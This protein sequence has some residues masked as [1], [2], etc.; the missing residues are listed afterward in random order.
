MLS[1][2][3]LQKISIIHP[4]SRPLVDRLSQVTK[5]VTLSKK[6]MLLGQGKICDKVYFI[7]KGIARAFHH[8]DGQDITSWLMRE[9][10]WIISVHSFYRQRP[11]YENIELLEDSIL[12]SLGYVELQSIYKDFP[13]FNFIGRVLTEYYYALSEERAFS[14]RLQSVKDRFESFMAAH[15]E[16]FNRVPLKYIASYA[17]WD[18]AFRMDL[19]VGPALI[20]P[21]KFDKEL[22]YKPDNTEVYFPISVLTYILF[23][24]DLNKE[25]HI[26]VI[27]SMPTAD[28]SDSI[29][30]QPFKGV[31]V[32]EN[33]QGDIISGFMF[34]KGEAYKISLDTQKKHPGALEVTTICITSSWYTCVTS[35]FG[36]NCYSESETECTSVTG[37]S[38]GNSG[39]AGSTAGTTGGGPS[40]DYGNIA[41]NTTYVVPGLRGNIISDIRDYLKC[42]DPTKP[43][44]VNI[45]VDQ[46]VPGTNANHDGIDVGHTFIGIT[47]QNGTAIITKYLGFYPAYDLSATPATPSSTSALGNDEGHTYDL[48]LPIQISSGQLSNLLNYI[49]NGTS[50]TYNLNSCNCTTWALNIAQ[51]CGVTLSR[52]IGCWAPLI[53]GCGVNPGDLGED[54]RTVPGAVSS[55]N[56]FA[57]AN[58][59]N[60]SMSLQ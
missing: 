34:R 15:P 21:V 4:L 56:S 54:L 19:S 35:M 50:T 45:Y 49:V 29:K 5:Q 59:G 10:D 13:E 6:T 36:S 40:T 1:E 8:K 51:I 3:I 58:T 44:T 9:G 18:K 23:Y 52:T 43:A 14:L 2:V 7:E 11:S 39:G 27:T 41:E 28:K 38:G 47:Q 17:V 57:P 42:F 55:P 20:V 12:T 31:V 22:Y 53:G 32:V 30:G 16:V 46:P 25:M 48:S 24:K 37:G 26:E 60:C 33:W